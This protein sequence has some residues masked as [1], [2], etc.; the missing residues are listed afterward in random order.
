MVPCHLR[1][2]RKSAAGRSCLSITKNRLGIEGWETSCFVS[3]HDFCRAVNASNETGLSR[4]CEN[5]RIGFCPTASSGAPYLPT[6]SS[7][8]DL[9]LRRAQPA[10]LKPAAS[11]EANV[12]VFLKGFWM[13]GVAGGELLNPTSPDDEAVGRYGAPRVVDRRGP[14]WSSHAPCEAPDLRQC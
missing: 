14:R 9:G 2:L 1:Q 3:G 12:S 6:A 13:F 5:Y 8:R 11:L 4:V 7:S 10:T